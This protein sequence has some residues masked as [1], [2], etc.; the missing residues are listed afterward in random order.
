MQSRK[1]SVGLVAGT[2]L[3]V[4]VLFAAPVILLG[5]VSPFAIRLLLGDAL[6]DRLVERRLV[7]DVG[8]LRQRDRRGE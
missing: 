8:L 6:L 1:L 2:L 5:C 4:V 7:D 3:A